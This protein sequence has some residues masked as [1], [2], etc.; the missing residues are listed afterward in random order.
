MDG[1]T[2]CLEDLERRLD[3]AAE[4]A[5]WRQWEAFWRGECTEPLFKPGIKRGAQPGFEWPEVHINDAVADNGLMVISQLR[6]VSDRLAAEEGGVMLG[7]RSNHGVGIL[8]SILGAQ[9]FMMSREQPCLPNSWPLE[10]G[11]EGIRAAL[12]RGVPDPRAGLGAR[13]LEVGEMLVEAFAAYPKVREH[14]HIYHPDLQGPMDVAELLWGS[15]I[16]L[17]LYDNAPLVHEFL[18]L[19]CDTYVAFMEEWW[20]LAPPNEELNVHWRWLW[21]GRVFLRDDSAM[22]LSSEMFEE[23]IFPYDQRLLSELGGGG[24]HACG[25]VDHWVGIASRMTDLHGFNISQPAYN[26]M[27][28]VYRHTVDKGIRLVSLDRATAE[29]AVAE[30]R[31]LHGLV[32]C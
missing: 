17:E 29:R 9:L 19:V 12:S 4:A 3:P 2:R 10:G 24:I 13:V 31:H 22:N 15:G 11:T 23:F 18:A 30:G 28:T 25:R 16:F 32:Q 26:H 5:L 14:V 1:I 7:V 8:P 6:G 27:E 20:K 21:K